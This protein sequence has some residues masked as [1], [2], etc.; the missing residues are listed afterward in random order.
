MNH[1]HIQTHKIYHGLD[2]G[3]A[4][5]F[6]LMV[7]SM[8]GHKAC[9]PNVIL[10]QDSQIGNPKILEIAIF[11]T[12]EANNFLCRPPIEVRSEVKL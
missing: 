7:F 6:P 5:T 4:T 2:L 9:T 1:E 8:F 10:S 11:G 12:L 3:E